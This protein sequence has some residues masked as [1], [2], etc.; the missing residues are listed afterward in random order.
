MLPLDDFIY[1]HNFPHLLT[2]SQKVFHIYLKTSFINHLMVNALSL[3]RIHFY[4]EIYNNF[5]L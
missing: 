3:I 5:I 1:Y 4:L 2:K